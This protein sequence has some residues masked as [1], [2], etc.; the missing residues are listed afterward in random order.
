MIVQAKRQ[1]FWTMKEHINSNLKR[2]N[3]MEWNG[4]ER[5]G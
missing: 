4:M 5:Y 2:R 1:N 3:G